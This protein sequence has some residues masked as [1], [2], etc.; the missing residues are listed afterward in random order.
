MILDH[1]LAEYLHSQILSRRGST[2]P[3]SAVKPAYRDLLTQEAE[4]AKID[5]GSQDS[6]VVTLPDYCGTR[7]DVSLTHQTM[8]SLFQPFMTEAF[9]ALKHTI[10]E[11]AR[12]SFEEIDCLLMVGG[13]SKLRGLFDDFRARGWSRRIMHPPDADWNIAQGAAITA[14]NPGTYVAGQDFGLAVSD[15]TYYPLIRDGQAIHVNNGQEHYFGM[16]ED[17]REARFVFVQPTG[18]QG[19]QNGNPLETLGYLSLPA[20]GFQDEPIALKTWLDED[21]VV[22]VRGHST[23]REP[24][25]RDWHYEKLRFRYRLPSRP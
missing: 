25:T 5:L 11:E 10:Q 21:L 16:V 14:S 15:G 12:C 4:R 9:E 18:R 1:T 24:E 23:R 6:V 8:R 7:A 17:S 2:I 22:N 13:T 20:Y 3:F 19:Y